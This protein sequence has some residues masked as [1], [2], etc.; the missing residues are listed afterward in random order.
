M[1]DK[2]IINIQDLD[3]MEFGDGGKFEAKLGRI[4]NVIGAQRLGYNLTVVP[5]GKRAF[6]FH[7]HHANEEMFFVI[8]G[9]GV[10]RYGDEE[11]P[12]KQGD[13]VACPPASG[14][15][16]QI[17]NSGAGE[18]KY[19]AVS[20]MQNPEICEYPDS[21]KVACLSG[22]WDDRKLSLILQKGDTVDYFEGE[23]EA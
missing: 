4:G 10:L 14:K 18:L 9:E 2:P 1:A 20:S 6:P 17:R 23:S 3:Y 5:P 19:L 16:H 12:V 7:M 11:Y 8:E 22:S 13:F 15:A 21:D